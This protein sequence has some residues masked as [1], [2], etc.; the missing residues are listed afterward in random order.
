MSTVTTARKYRTYSDGTTCNQFALDGDTVRA[1]DPVSG[2][3]TV[4][5]ALTAR[6]QKLIR[7]EARAKG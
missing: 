4:C 3:Y 7:A 2:T 1:L 5:H 6:Q